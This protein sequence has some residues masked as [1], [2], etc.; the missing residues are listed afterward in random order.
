MALTSCVEP[1]ALMRQRGAEDDDGRLDE[2]FRTGRL[3]EPV[4]RAGEEVA[5]DQAGE[6]GDDEAGLARQAQR[7]GDAE[8]RLLVGRGGDKGVVPQQP[9]QVA[10]AEDNG[11]AQGEPAKVEPQE[12]GAQEQHRQQKQVG[13]QETKRPG[14][15]IV[16]FGRRRHRLAGADPFVRLDD[17]AEHVDA[18]EAQGGERHQGQADQNRPS[19]FGAK[20]RSHDALQWSPVRCSRGEI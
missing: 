19:V 2:P 8:A 9:A 10:D 18:R 4:G 7:P 20:P 11:E 13:E 5:D 16:G 1:A 12:P 14:Q 15:R 3:L 6:Q 17:P